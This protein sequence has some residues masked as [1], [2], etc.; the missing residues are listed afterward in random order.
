MVKLDH[1]LS[2][3]LFSRIIFGHKFIKTARNNFGM[4]S[5]HKKQGHTR[6]FVRNFHV[7]ESDN[8]ERA[9]LDIFGIK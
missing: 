7:K 2:S 6:K 3:V 4:F 8:F 5:Y 9:Y 1:P